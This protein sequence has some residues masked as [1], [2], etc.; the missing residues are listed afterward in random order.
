MTADAPLPSPKSQPVLP[1]W[2]P[3]WS[4][5]LAGLYFSGTINTF[6]LYGNVHDLVRCQFE[7]AN[8]FISLADFLATQLFGSWDVALSY[9][10]GR[11]L[12]AV[13]GDDSK[14][15]QSMV[16]YLSS[17]MGAANTWPRD[18]DKSFDVLEPLLQR[19]L[20]EDNV[21]KQPELYQP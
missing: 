12:R 6:V 14:R 18:P 7:N 13:A 21:A 11:G 15:L 1:E 4:K 9:D 17:V 10:L 2:Y 20:L 3:A 16:Q 5:E 19:N 8:S